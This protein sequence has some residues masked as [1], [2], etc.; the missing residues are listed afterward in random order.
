MKTTQMP[1]PGD[2]VV[3]TDKYSS[4]GGKRFMVCNASLLCKKDE[5]KL[6][7]IWAVP[8]NIS[9]G[10]IPMWFCNGSYEIVDTNIKPA[11]CQDCKGTGKIVLFTSTIKCACIDSTK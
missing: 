10:N 8:E 4:F 2:I 6:N 1:K 5:D 7:R 11:I 3:I 9:D